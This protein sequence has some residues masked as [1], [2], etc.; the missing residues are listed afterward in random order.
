MAPQSGASALRCA[1]LP[2]TIRWYKKTQV[3]ALPEGGWEVLLDDRSIN[4]PKNNELRIPTEALAYA[5]AQVRY[6]CAL[7]LFSC[8]KKEWEAQS[9]LL[10]PKDYMP[11]VRPVSCR[12]RL[13]DRGRTI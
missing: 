10:N 5:I 11:L 8:D 13:A 2:P 1:H 6:R 3:V 4:T 12:V 9:T 7:H